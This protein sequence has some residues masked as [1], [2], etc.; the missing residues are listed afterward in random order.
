MRSLQITRLFDAPRNVVF[1]WWSSGEKLQQW[2]GCKEATRC[3][4]QMD[5][6]VGGGFTQKMQIAGKD[7]F[8]ITATYD[9]IVAPERITYH[10]DLGVA[11]TRVQ[12][13]FFDEA[14]KTKVVLTQDG[15]PDEMSVKIVTGGTTESLE[16]LESIFAA[17][18][19][20]IR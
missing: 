1:S 6:R 4:V 7:T 17:E 20:A 15:F 13:E 5:F 3:E 10:V 16:K 8:T 14:G 19:Q 11:V 2:S 12:V 9:E 18:A